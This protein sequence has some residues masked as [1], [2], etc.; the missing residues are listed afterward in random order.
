M[1]SAFSLPENYWSTLEITKQDVKS[2][3]TYLFEAETPLTA[4]DLTSVFV[5]ARIQ[6]ERQA[7]AAQRQAGGKTYKPA[8]KYQAGDDLVFPA[9]DWK[10]GKVTATRPGVNPEVAV[11]DVITVGLED[12]SSRMFAAGLSEHL[13]NQEPTAGAEDECP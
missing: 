13:L 7:R 6:A 12:G 10:K 9:L 4:H 11:F 1:A 3:N 8:E 2:L 5:T